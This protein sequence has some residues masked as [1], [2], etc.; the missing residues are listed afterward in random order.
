MFADDRDRL[1]DRAGMLLVFQY[2][3]RPLNVRASENTRD[4]HS[5]CTEKWNCYP[6]NLRTSSL[7][8][9][10]VFARHAHIQRS[11]GDRKFEPNPQS[12]IK[13]E[14]LFGDWI[15]RNTR[16]GSG[17]LSNLGKYVVAFM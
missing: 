9:L 4:P 15:W 5:F 6:T 3:H 11:R 7:Q 17:I 14:M 8:K 1:I 10:G 16:P 13:A 12:S 2:D